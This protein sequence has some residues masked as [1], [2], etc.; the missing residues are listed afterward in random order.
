VSTSTVPTVLAGL[1][2]QLRAAVDP[3]TVFD[4]PEITGD[5][6]PVAVIVGYNGDPDSEFRAVENWVQ[7]WAPGLGGGRKEEAFDV[8]G[9]V[10][11]FSGDTTIGDKR[12]AV[13]ATFAAVEGVLRPS[14]LPAVLGLPSPAAAL[15]SA[16]EFYQEQTPGG[17]Q[18]RIPFTVS[19]TRVRI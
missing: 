7:P 5:V 1:V 9:C 13:F 11:A 12:T 15:F 2:T 6:P 17:L 3:L 14:T 18:C 8:L 16:G 10:V 19:I 4:G